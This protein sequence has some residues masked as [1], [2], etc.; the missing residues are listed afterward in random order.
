MLTSAEFVYSPRIC[1]YQLIFHFI[2]DNNEG[3]CELEKLS[4]ED[5][6]ELFKYTCE[7]TKKEVQFVSDDNILM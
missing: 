3:S 7:N 2:H 4:K 6:D 5:K 1:K